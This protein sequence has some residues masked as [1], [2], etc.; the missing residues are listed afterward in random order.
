MEL[1][2]C[3]VWREH[4]SL[5]DFSR[6]TANIGRRG[7]S[8]TLCS[9]FWVWWTILNWR[10]L[11]LFNLFMCGTVTIPTAAA[12]FA[13]SFPFSC[14][15]VEPS[16]EEA[17]PQTQGSKKAQPAAHTPR[18][19]SCGCIFRPKFKGVFC[20][21]WTLDLNEIMALLCYRGIILKTLFCSCSIVSG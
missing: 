2:G 18:N 17:T 5:Q 1:V 15:N 9:S 6:A 13:L 3:W 11:Q 14:F 21:F 20:S 8:S 10:W 12:H 7:R 19:S 16:S 4:L